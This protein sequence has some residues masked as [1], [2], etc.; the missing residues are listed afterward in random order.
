VKTNHL[1]LITLVAIISGTAD[2]A[3]QATRAE[4]AR[5]QREAKA[6]Q[7][8]P[9]K[10]GWLDATL[11]KVEDSLLIERVLFPPRGVHLRLGG[12]GEGA[13]FG[14][15]P[16]FRYSTSQFDFR[17]SGAASLKRYAIGEAA[18]LLPGVVRNGPY[19]ELYGRWRDF[20]Q[21]DFYGLGPT[22][23]VE[24]RSN[25]ALRDTLF[26]VTPGLRRGPLTA[27]IGVAALDARV[28]RGT[29]KLMPPVQDVFFA[30]SLPGLEARP[31]FAT[32]EPFVEYNYADP[33]LAPT[34]GGHYRLAFSQYNDRDLER[35]SFTR[36]DVDVRQYLP[37]FH[38][39][40]TIAL[41]AWVASADPEGGHDVPF[42]L[43]P[44][45]GGAYSLRGVRTFRFRDRSALL[46]QAEYRWRINDFMT[47][48][49]FYDTGAVARRLED[50]ENLER[51]YGV[52]IRLGGR[53][54][55]AFRA[56]VAFGSGEGT[57]LL[58]RFNNVF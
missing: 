1:A 12:V 23:L 50:I 19:V 3:A 2:A 42:Y 36:W 53:T 21:E 48:A 58:L 11:F 9:Q 8:Q 4:E 35:F 20:P 55:V 49:L 16:G 52:G 29:D 5:A 44:T 51:D 25:Y 13:G 38:E 22:S 40:R 46:L 26:R 56:D 47:G 28:G 17:V 39:T 45:L 14:V 43:Q 18:L 10:R 34:R 37:L 27:G 31:T 33:P 41:R 15:G 7:V 57:R 30:D 24:Q 32:V 54:G 6:R